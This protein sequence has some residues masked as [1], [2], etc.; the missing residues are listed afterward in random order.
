MVEFHETGI[1][2]SG[3]GS[4]FITLIPKVKSPEGL[5]DYR[6]I[7]LIGVISKVIS[8]ILA[9]HLKKILGKV[10]SESQ[11]AFLSDRFI[12]DGPLVVNEVLES[13]KKGR[14]RWIKGILESARA[15]VLVNGSPT[16]QFKSE[17]GLRQG[18]PISPFLFLI[19]MECLSW[20]LEK[21][22]ALEVLKGIN[23]LFDNMDI[24]HLFFA[25]DALIMGEWSRE[26]IFKASGLG[27]AKLE[28]VNDALLLKW[29]WRF[30]QSGNCLWKRLVLSCHG[31]SRT[32]S[33]LPCTPSASGC[34]KQIVKIGEK[35]IWNGNTLGS[36]FVGI[37]GDGST[38]N[39]WVDSWIRNAPLR[40]VYPNLFR[41]EKNKWVSVSARLQVHNGI[42]MLQ[43]DWRTVPSSPVEINELF[44]LMSDI[45]DYEW[46]G[47]IDKWI[48]TGD[49]NGDFSVSKAKTLMHQCQQP[50]SNNRMKWKGWVPLKCK[51]MV[52]QAML[53][54]MPTKVD[55]SKHG[56]T[57]PNDLCNLCDSE[58]ETTNHLFIGCA[59]AADIW[60]RVLDKLMSTGIDIENT[61]TVIVV[62]TIK[63]TQN[64][65]AKAATQWLAQ[66]MAS[67]TTGDDDED[68]DDD[69]DDLGFHVN[70][71]LHCL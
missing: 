62:T 69:D 19:V 30:K 27:V 9:N 15:S 21:A 5:K 12:L 64:V 17:K 41:L 70:G 38:I 60:A 42:K 51:I 67:Q 36:Y 49:S 8:K 14:K 47:G 6:P 56:V 44:G 48:W 45:Y 66:V 63:Q 11:S 4:A 18:D 22:K 57:L 2:N 7:T 39:F 32:W 34:W 59:F 55:L 37:L 20:M 24:T 23:F 29:A 10:I 68:E 61:N 50:S 1:I 31:S 13:L 35:K 54:R 71:V 16:F 65:A 33:L 25:D 58:A 46:K 26:R 52:W 28:D 43:W 40:L 53:N 3:C